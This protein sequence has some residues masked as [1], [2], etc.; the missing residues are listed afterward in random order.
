MNK[1]LSVLQTALFSFDDVVTSF[2]DVV[3]SFDDDAT[4]FDARGKRQ[5]CSPMA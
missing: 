3:T 1:G 4:S 2:D 5:F